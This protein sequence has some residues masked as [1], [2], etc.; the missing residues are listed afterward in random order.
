M[1][2]NFTSNG[3]RTQMEW[4]FFWLFP[5]LSLAS[6]IESSPQMPVKEIENYFHSLNVKSDTIVIIPGS[7]CDGCISHAQKFLVKNLERSNTNVT[8]ILTRIDDSKVIKRRLKLFDK[9]NE[10]I[11]IFD[12][13]NNLLYLGYQSIYPLFI[14][15]QD[16]KIEKIDFLT[17]E[18]NGILGEN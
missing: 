2:Y 9:L 12:K 6:C 1:D 4:H 8:F 18:N 16:G 3:S 7:G 17:P 10:Q 14:T 15:L 13:Q 5:L 11:I